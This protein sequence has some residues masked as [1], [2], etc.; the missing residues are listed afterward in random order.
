MR[1]IHTSKKI[2]PH[3]RLFHAFPI[4]HFGAQAELKKGGTGNSK[5]KSFH[6][7]VSPIITVNDK[8]LNKSQILI[9]VMENN[10]NKLNCI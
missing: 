4:C 1:L 10:W 3:Q 5:K 2:K 6:F 8:K 7:I 9:I